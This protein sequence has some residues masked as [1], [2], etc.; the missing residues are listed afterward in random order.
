[1][2][3]ET[4]SG[5]ARRL[6][7]KY[8]EDDPERLCRAMGVKIERIP[9][10]KS[11]NACKGFFIRKSRIKRIV[12]NADLPARDQRIILLHELGHAAL[13]GNIPS[14]CAF[15]DFAPFDEAFRYEYEANIF[16]AEFAISNAEVLELLGEGNSFF[17]AARSLRVPPELLDFKFR[18]MKRQG[19]AIDPPLYA[20]SAFMKDID[21]S[22]RF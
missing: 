18:I 4:I 21:R 19:Y 12:L 8:G 16:A 3:I 17:G 15:H 10:G 22:D 6:K 14:G 11:P 5:I 9:M 1:M 2:T 7:G 13:H 20:N